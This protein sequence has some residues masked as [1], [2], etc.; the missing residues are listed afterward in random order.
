METE[1]QPAIYKSFIIGVKVYLNVKMYTRYSDRKDVFISDKYVVYLEKEL[2]F[3]IPE[4]K[5]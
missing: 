1:Y 3:L 2:T 4:G 5:K